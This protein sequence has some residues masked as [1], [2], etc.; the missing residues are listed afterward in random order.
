MKHADQ[1]H[2]FVVWIRCQPLHTDYIDH[3]ADWHL[4]S[5]AVQPLHTDYNID[6]LAD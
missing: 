4:L 1:Y 2:Y 5:L 3:L 6:H